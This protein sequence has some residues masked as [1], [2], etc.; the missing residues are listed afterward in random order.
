MLSNNLNATGFLSIADRLRGAKSIELALT[1]GWSV[2]FEKEANNDEALWVDFYYNGS[3]GRDEKYAMSL[4]CDVNTIDSLY[5]MAKIKASTDLQ[6]D[7]GKAK[8]KGC[9]GLAVYK[10]LCILRDA[11]VQK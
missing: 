4:R 10:N 11:E 2:K 7:G 6:T 3:I 1:R 9:Y 5:E 8:Y